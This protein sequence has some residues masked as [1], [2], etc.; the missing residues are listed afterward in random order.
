[1]PMTDEEKKP[2]KHTIKMNGK[3]VKD[4]TLHFDEDGNFT[5]IQIE[6]AE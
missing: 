1:M 3:G 4:I 6:Y 5:E 2:V